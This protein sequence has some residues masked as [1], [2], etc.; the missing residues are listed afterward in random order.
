MRSTRSTGP[1]RRSD[2]SRARALRRAA[3]MRQEGP[4]RDAPARA[5]R[6]HV[7]APPR[8]LLASVHVSSAARPA[9]EADALSNLCCC[10]CCCCCVSSLT[11]CCRSAA[12]SFSPLLLLPPRPRC[13]THSALVAPVPAR[14]SI[15]RRARGRRRARAPPR[16]AARPRSAAAPRCASRVPPSRPTDSS[17]ALG[18]SIPRRGPLATRVE[19]RA[20]AG[21]R[22]HPPLRP[23][24]VA[25]AARRATH[26]P[27]PPLSTFGLR[28]T[29]RAGAGGGHRNFRVPHNPVRPPARRASPSSSGGRV[30]GIYC[31][32]Y[33]VFALHT[34][35]CGAGRLTPD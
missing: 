17:S 5:V 28:L 24:P 9:L 2:A 10:C 16:A 12:P 25:P 13:R 19:G 18:S 21:R 33:S 27:P 15:S 14:A 23:R 4:P 11:C 22:L 30:I 7:S 29:S 31:R 1:K 35:E 8:A 20:V 3:A 32:V 34:H 6:A 26:P